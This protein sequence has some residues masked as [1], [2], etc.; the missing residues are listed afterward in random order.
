MNKLTSLNV[1]KITN[2][3]LA[4]VL[5]VLPFSSMMQVMHWP[6]GKFLT[7]S[8][9]IIIA[10]VYVFR[11]FSKTTISLKDHVKLILVF[12]ACCF[13][14]MINFKLGHMNILLKLLEAVF[15]LFLFLELRDL[16]LRK[17]SVRKL[18]GFQW[19]GM[20]LL[21]VYGCW[22]LLHLPY[23]VVPLIGSLLAGL[24]LS[25]GFLLRREN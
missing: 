9:Y 25:V 4:I 12:T 10:L 1:L 14:L 21:M 6:F 8:S 22:K 20:L 19:I 23:A 7:S 2:I 13:H 15:L 18:N 5:V 3:I 16:I 11:Y 17:A 24:F